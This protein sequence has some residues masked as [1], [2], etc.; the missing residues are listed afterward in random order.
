MTVYILFVF[1]FNILRKNISHF[2]F[3]SPKGVHITNHVGLL[4]KSNKSMLC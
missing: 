4:S 3:F 1:G 2:G